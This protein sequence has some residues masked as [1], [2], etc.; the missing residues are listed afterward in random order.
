[1]PSKVPFGPETIVIQ[2]HTQYS[3]QAT[4]GSYYRVNDPLTLYHFQDGVTYT[5]TGSVSAK[6]NKYI[7]EV[8]GGQAPVAQAPVQQPGLP[9]LPPAPTPQAQ[10]FTPPVATPTAQPTPAKPYTPQFKKGGDNVE[11]KVACALG[12]GLV[13]YLASVSTNEAEFIAK[14]QLLLP[15]LIQ[16]HKEKGWI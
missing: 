1:M 16:Y 2:R 9:P 13:Q 11:G 8:V 15:Q 4:D 7:S 3:L 5:V 12:A 6:G 14:Y 10:V